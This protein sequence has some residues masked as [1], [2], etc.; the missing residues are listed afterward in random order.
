MRP[1]FV[2]RSTDVPHQLAFWAWPRVKSHSIHA[3]IGDL[4]TR[5]RR[6]NNSMKP[7]YFACLL[8]TTFLFSQIAQAQGQI[9]AP[10]V[11]YSSGG[12]STV[13][14]GIGQMSMG[15]GNSAI[16]DVNG[17]G[18]ADLV[19]ATPFASGSTTTKSGLVSVLLGN[20]DGTF[21]A[22]VNYSSGGFGAVFVA[23][24][25]VNGDGKPDL[26]VA[27]SCL[28]YSSA[29]QSGQVN[30]T[31]GVLL[32]N[33]DGT[34]QPV[35]T[36][37]V[38]GY[39][40]VSVA[41]ADVNG[42]GKPDLLVASSCAPVNGLCTNGAVS[43]LL[44]NGDGTFQSAVTYSSGGYDSI[45]MAVRDVNGDGKPDLIVANL[46]PVSSSACDHYLVDGTVGVLLGNGDGTFQAAV[47]YDSGGV[48][49]YSVAAADVNGDGKPD[50]IVA[51]NCGGGGHCTGGPEAKPIA[52]LLGNGDG[53][54]RPA[55]TYSSGGYGAVS[56]AVADVN[57]DGKP[58]LVDLVS[59][60]SLNNCTNGIVGVL[61]GNGDGTFQPAITY[62]SGGYVP[63]SLTLGDLNSDGKPDAVALNYFANS[64]LAGNTTPSVLLNIGSPT[65]TLPT[66]LTIA[67]SLNPSAYGQSVTFI[68][69]VI[70]QG[71]VTPT[72]TVTLSDGMNTLGASPL[73]GGTATLTT[74]AL[75]VGAHSLNALYSG[76][77]NY[78]VSSA[79]PNQAVNPSALTVVANN[80]SVAFG[81]PIPALTGTLT[82][83]V[84]GDGITASYTTTAVPGSAVGQYA[85]TPALNDPNSKLSDYSVTK[86]SGTLAITAQTISF[87]NPGTQT[88]GASLTPTAT[89]TSGFP[90]TYTVTSGPAT[91]NGST[92]TFTGTGSATIQAAQ[93]GN[94][95]SGAATPVS[96]TISVLQ[97]PLTISPNS[98]SRAVGAAN[99]ALTGTVAGAEN[100]D[101]NTGSLVTTYSTTAGASSP[102]GTYP[103][104]ASISGAAAGNY[105]LTVNPATLTV[106]SV[107]LIESAVTGP[108]SVA[109]GGTIQVTD[110]V[111]NQGSGTAGTSTTGFYLST[112]GQ[113]LGTLLT[114][115]IVGTLAGGASN[116]PVTTTLTLPANLNGTYYMI[117]CT[118]YNDSVVETNYANNCTASAP[119]QVAGA[120]LIESSF[121]VTTT[122]PVSGGS[123]SVSDTATN[124]GSGTAGTSTTGFYLSTDGKTLGTLLATRIVGTLAA[125]A[126]SG[127][128]TTTITL[129]R[130]IG[131]TYYMIAC[132]NYSDS[133]MET[134]YTN[135]CKASAAFQVIGT[136]LIESSFSVLTTAPGSGGKLSVSDTVTNQGSGTAST[137]TTGYYWST[138]GKTLGTFLATRVVGS[139][140][141]G[142]S[143]GPVTTS[144]TLPTNLNGTY[145]MI[146]CANYNDSLLETNYA[147]NCT[148]SAPIQVAGADLI[149]SSFSVTTTAPVSGGKIS[150]SDTAANQGLGIAGTSTT[151]FY[152]STDG[153]TLGT[154]LATRVVST[155]AAGAN[156][157]PVTTTI[158]LPTNLNGTYYI[159]ACADYNDSV[160]ETSYA[161]NC[162]AS[163]PMQVAGADLTESTV[164][165]LT[166]A[167]VSGGS[168][169]VS[170]TATNQG[171]GIAGSSTTGFYFS[172]NGTTLSTLLKTRAIGTLAAGASSG[173]VTTT[174]TLPTNL[175]GT[176]YIIACAN[177]NNGVVEAATNTNNCTA[178]APMLVP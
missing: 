48:Y 80:S 9:F 146:A 42:D 11:A 101:L 120:D 98:Y 123:L 115:R 78:S 130:S 159:I 76:D 52:V 49:A 135:N 53:T 108:A 92:L 124:Q 67:S 162:T 75:A 163:A 91:L 176:Y 122:A 177:Y 110:T 144:I 51:N 35:V 86:T 34:F 168:I 161:N 166:T 23:V 12:Y 45:S 71:T 164:S 81:S 39:A 29:C 15:A 90:I 153:K 157:G 95:N 63:W 111:L 107:D 4:A 158:T 54:F 102:A 38:G 129:P 7:I 3:R 105:A 55:V 142:A 94:A 77:A 33:G 19:V 125:A 117:A 73:S 60:A 14:S 100:N 31:V 169:S 8:A 151:G 30:S 152:F 28:Q 127:A 40:A 22:A 17:D 89:A 138:D 171:P 174:M 167:P 150:V 88:Y 56:V 79:S 20:G 69:S 97:A 118:D 149:E 72:G 109:S 5:L 96:V 70:P 16:A 99:P 36:Y 21:Q 93:A 1:S 25:D 58:D 57:G 65:A 83:M 133:M 87:P 6:K 2:R 160:V 154:F 128:V 148:A 104:T 26:V 27:N 116:G 173:P 132:A 143:N 119:M 61:L 84:V 44:G 46:C 147:N 134:N 170:D 82:G 141:A 47:T 64:S 155:L 106:L 103:I 59:C 10:A 32:G 172:T 68:A 66:T 136:D 156:S 165:V 85:I 137:S 18:K 126:N 74:A 24:A 114:T 121:S 41:V 43:V 131:G 178:S 37:N 175:N 112:D 50:L 140:A 113:T 13:T 145:Y 62:S 139:L